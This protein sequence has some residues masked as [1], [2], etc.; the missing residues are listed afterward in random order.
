[1]KNGEWRMKKRNER[2]H[3]GSR[4]LH[5]S[6]FILHS[7]LFLVLSGCAKNPVLSGPLPPP[8]QVQVE[9][10]NP[11]YQSA[12]DD[13]EK[14]GAQVQIL[15]EK[16]DRPGLMIAF[17]RSPATDA[18][19]EYVKPLKAVSL[20]LNRST[21]TEKG[22]E[23]LK[24]MTA[25]NVLTLGQTQL[26]DKALAHLSKLTK[27]KTLTLGEQHIT[28]AGLQ[29]LRDLTNLNTLHIS[30]DQITDEGLTYLRPLKK[31]NSLVIGG[32]NITDRGLENLKDLAALRFLGVNSPLITDK[33]LENLKSLTKLNELVLSGC[34]NIT[35]AGLQN[36]E[37]MTALR[38]VY[39]Q[40]CAKITDAGLEHIKNLGNPE[41]LDLTG[42][43]VSD[44]GVKSL[45]RAIPGLRITR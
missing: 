19:L 21:V 28:D 18:D 1:M 42:T 2:A 23:C 37:E 36:L 25:L 7:L 4:F 35:D 32:Q 26:T 14:R 40:G 17:A 44:A 30:S 15:E 27:L 34:P 33:G 9:G 3:R 41:T 12:I 22:L 24:E 16:S 6:F 45:Q 8:K 31:L 13:L 39:L 29:Q 10:V 38:S 5:S 11:Q 43:S 20:N